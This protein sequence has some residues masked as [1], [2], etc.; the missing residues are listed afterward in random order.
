MVSK[1]G[2]AQF[3]DEAPYKWSRRWCDEPPVGTEVLGDG[4]VEIHLGRG[5]WQ[6]VA[7]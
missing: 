1:N 6:T 5:I 7:A 3:V 4:L 2:D